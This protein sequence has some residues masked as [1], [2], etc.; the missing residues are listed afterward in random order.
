MAKTEI[1]STQVKDLTVLVDDLRDF[2]PTDGGGLNLNVAA[3]RIRN[4]NTVTD[5]SAVVV[6]LTDNT[7]NFVEIDDSGVASANTSAFTSGKIPIAQVVTSGA[8][9]STVTDKRVWVSAGGNPGSI[10]SELFTATAGQTVF[11]LTEFTYTTGSEELLVFSGG[12]L[13]RLTEDYVETSSTVIT[14][15][16]GRELDENV[17][18]YKIRPGSGTG[19]PT[20]AQYVVLAAN[21]TLT[22]ERVLTAGNNISV[23]DAGAG[24]TVT[25]AQKDT[26]ARVRHSV[27]VSIANNTVVVL[28]F[29]TELFDTDTLHDVSVNNSRLTVNTAGKYLFGAII[30]WASNTTGFRVVNLRVNGTAGVG[31]SRVAVNAGS[32]EPVQIPNTVSELAANDFIEVI[33]LQNSGGALNVLKDTDGSLHFWIV[34]LA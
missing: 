27:N 25:V 28:P 1:R 30:N 29:D 15:N 24:S 3:G 26:S 20:D 19:G 11:T 16:T 12:L 14:F 2:G 21:G 17:T 4:D 23:T 31:P 13:M 8:A 6:A 22:D 9:I 10:N 7:T 18:F 32:P 34:R 5:V 33:V